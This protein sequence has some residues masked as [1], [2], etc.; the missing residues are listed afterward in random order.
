LR[1]HTAMI[2]DVSWRTD[3]NILASAS[4]DGTVRLW[5]M[6]NGGNVKNWAAHPGGVESVRFAADGRLATTGRDRLTK[7][8]D[9]NGGLQKQFPAF[10]DLGLRVAVTH[11][12]KVIAGDWS[13]ALRLWNPADARQLAA[14]DTNP[15]PLAEQLKATEQAIAAAEARA[16]QTADT[17]AAAQARAKQAGDAFAAAQ[18]NAAKVA[19]DLAAARKSASDHASAAAAAAPQVAAAK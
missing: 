15:L 3:S 9:G 18:A 1:G 8:W 7:L 6:E 17:L 13:G 10:A 2:T 16:K 19:A 12:G 4:E 14:M 11:D 5:E